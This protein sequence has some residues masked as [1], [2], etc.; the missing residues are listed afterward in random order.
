[1]ICLA[2]PVAPAL[3][4]AFA[5]AFA[6][7]AA[8]CESKTAPVTTTG[9]A[10]PSARPSAVPV[11]R[12]EPDE[13]AQGKAVVFGFPVP[14]DMTVERMYPDAVHI[15]GSAR[16]EAV[17][18]YVRKRVA[19]LHVEIGAARTVFPAARING[20]KTHHIYRIEVVANAGRTLLVI[21]D[22]TPPPTAQGLSE[23][24][25]WKRAGL[26]PDGKIADPRSLE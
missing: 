11:D 14:R 13:L 9:T 22:I 23:A 2:R 18:N 26:T 8:G 5:F 1:M 6:L 4:F 7:A 12:L 21:R 25:R 10:Q 16:P 24:E 20:D 15:V 3:A 17:A 19:A